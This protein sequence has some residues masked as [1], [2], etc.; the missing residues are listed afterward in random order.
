MH[1]IHET[2]TYRFR[3]E[4]RL[5]GKA[6][7]AG[8]QMAAPGE[9]AEKAHLTVLLNNLVLIACAEEHLAEIRQACYQWCL[10]Q[11]WR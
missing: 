6:V 2:N 7:L 3:H 5:K 10:H 8:T 1:R 11:K 9:L 4:G